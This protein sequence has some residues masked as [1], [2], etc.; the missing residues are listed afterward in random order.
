MGGRTVAKLLDPNSRTSCANV[1]QTCFTTSQFATLATQN[2]FGNL[3]RNSFRQA[4]YFDID[5]SLLKTIT[6]REGVRFTFG[7]S[8]YHTL[9]HPNFGSPGANVAPAGFGALKWPL[10][11]P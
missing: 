4:G 10:S 8:A 9:N 6:I 5:T 1:D 2:S 11:A 3:P 7:A